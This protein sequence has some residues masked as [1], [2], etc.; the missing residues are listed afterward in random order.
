ML[1]TRG[2]T[3]LPS[4]IDLICLHDLFHMYGLDWSRTLYHVLL[5]VVMT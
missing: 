4:L 1:D 5:D 3:Y 2:F